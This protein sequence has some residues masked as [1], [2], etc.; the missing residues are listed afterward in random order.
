[1]NN[2][3]NVYNRLI[4]ENEI[5]NINEAWPFVLG[6]AALMGAGA[7]ASYFDLIP[8]SIKKWQDENPI[9]YGIAQIIDPTGILSWPTFDDALANWDSDPTSAWNNTMLLLSFLAMVPVIGV[10][11]RTF[12]KIITYVPK[13]ALQFLGIKVANVIRKS[14][15]LTRKE[16]PRIMAQLYGKNTKIDR[17]AGAVFN[18]FLRKNGITIEKKYIVKELER[19]GVKLDPRYI[20]LVGY[21]KGGVAKALAA[22]AKI[23]GTVA[24]GAAKLGGALSRPIA[25][26]WDALGS[27]SEE[28]LKSKES[29][30]DFLKKLPR[31]RTKAVM[32]PKYNLVGPIGATTPARY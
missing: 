17:D 24:T 5:K 20:D 11:A 9:V 7:A 19:Q 25:A 28:D 12:G 26:T 6:G 18:E 32:G 2:F 16:L 27:P 30:I 10:G 15:R 3:D 14:S 22:L 4:S 1:M 21:E 23:T 8:D 13:K 31:S 29:L